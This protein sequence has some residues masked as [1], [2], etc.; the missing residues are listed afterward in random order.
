MGCPRTGCTLSC[1]SSSG[2]SEYSH[3]GPSPAVGACSVN[4]EAPVGIK[5]WARGKGQSKTGLRGHW[6]AEATAKGRD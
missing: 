5:P 3:T 4:S 1:G 2:V 6:H